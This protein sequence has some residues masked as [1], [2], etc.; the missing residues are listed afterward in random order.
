MT[1]V[2]TRSP[3]NLGRFMR[4][5]CLPFLQ[6]KSVINALWKGELRCVTTHG[7]KNHLPMTLPKLFPA[8]W[9]R[10]SC[11]HATFA[12]GISALQR[13][14]ACEFWMTDSI[15]KSSIFIEFLMPWTWIRRPKDLF[16]QM[17]FVRYYKTFVFLV[18]KISS[19]RMNQSS[20]GIIYVIRYGSITKWSVRKSQSKKLIQKSA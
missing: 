10:G 13:Q 11:F 20:F 9:R 18:S 7:L 12:V 5:R 19:L 15:W 17:K 3:L 2:L 4:Q 1:S 6:W 8:C 16:S 14:P